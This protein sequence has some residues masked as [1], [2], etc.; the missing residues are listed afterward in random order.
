MASEDALTTGTQS[1]LFDTGGQQFFVVLG[2]IA[3]SIQCIEVAVVPPATGYETSLVTVYPLLFW[4]CFGVAI[5]AAVTVFIGSVTTASRRWRHALVLLLCDYGMFFSLP[6]ARGYKLYG[7]GQSDSL[8]HLGNV[9]TILQTGNVYDGLIYPLE[10][11]LLS[12][13]TM[14]GIPLNAAR[15]L[16]SFTFTVVF[17]CSTGLLLRRLIDSRVRALAIGLCAGVPLIFTEYQISTLPAVLSF[18]LFPLVMV[19]LERHRRTRANRFAVLLLA[20]GFG[21]VFFHPVTTLFFVVLVLSTVAF[22]RLYERVHHSHVRYLWPGVA[23]VMIPVAFNWYIDFRSTQNRLIRVLEATSASAG[24]STVGRASEAPLT[25]AQI[26]RRFVQLYGGIFIYLLLAGLFCLVV[27]VRVLQQRDTYAESYLA[28]QFIIGFGIAVAFLSIYLI[29]YGPIRVSRYMLLMAVLLVALLLYR[30][31][32]AGGRIQR[33]VPVLIG[34]AIVSAAVLSAFA[35]YTPKKGMTHAEYEGAEFMIEHYNDGLKIRSMS[36][37]D[38][39]IEYVTGT[40]LNDFDTE[41]FGRG[42]EYSLAPQLGYN[43]NNTVAQ[44]FGRSYLVTQEHDMEFYT[45]RYYTETQQE[46]LS[47]YNETDVMQMYR[48]PTVHKVYANGGLEGWYI[49]TNSTRNP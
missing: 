4:V 37:T 23:L 33:I 44:S 25:I 16:L 47:V 41:P 21:I 36:I 5:G 48:D 22:D 42:P 13:L 29:A 49:P 12:V 26:L 43:R 9:K 1:R 40:G 32:T 19:V 27:L 30:S 14:T 8:V 15:Y 18:M 6:I 20:F 35:A 31:V 11:L 2:S 45:A 10:H 24:A 28:Y 3:V 34:L 39:M 46:M 7:R 17:I 38:N